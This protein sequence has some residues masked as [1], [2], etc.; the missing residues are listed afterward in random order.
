MQARYKTQLD[1]GP[2][3]HSSAKSCQFLWHWVSVRL[4]KN[5][6]RRVSMRKRSR[7]TAVSL[8][9]RLSTCTVQSR[10]IV[11]FLLFRRVRLLAL[12]VFEHSWWKSWPK[13]SI[14]HLAH[15]QV[16]SLQNVFISDITKANAQSWASSG[17]SC[18]FWICQIMGR[19]AKS[20]CFTQFIWSESLLTARSG[21]R[22]MWR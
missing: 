13:S 17:Q 6:T 3:R 4:P 20:T 15:L 22:K 9:R 18:L 7:S 16:Q 21:T 14:N 11:Y 2:T 5:W 10:T 12:R 19:P 8:A 1:S